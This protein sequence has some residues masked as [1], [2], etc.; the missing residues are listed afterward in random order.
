MINKIIKNQYLLNMINKIISLL[1]GILS[2]AFITRY[3][4]SSLKG[5]YS[6]IVSV[7]SVVSIV[8]NF[9]IYQAY[10]YQIKQGLKNAQKKFLNIFAMQFILYIII[11]GTIAICTKDFKLAGIALIIPF[12]VLVSQVTMIGMVE[13]PTF[14]SF[15]LIIVAFVNVILCYITFKF[16]SRN[17]Y[18]SIAILLIKDVI[19]II[20]VLIKARVFPNPFIIDVKLFFE[21]FKFGLLPMLTTLLLNMNY[22]MDIVMLRQFDTSAAVGIYSVGVS[23]ADY[24]WLIP[25]SF[26]E[27]LFSRAAKENS[28]NSFNLSIKLSTIMTTVISIGV[29]SLGR[30]VISFLY[31]SE[32]F[33]S[34][35]ITVILLIGIPFMSIFKIISPLFVSQGKTKLYFIILLV[36]IVINFVLNYILIAVMSLSG[37]AFATIISQIICGMFTLYM[38][39]KINN[40]RTSSVFMFNR[41]EIDNIKSL[42]IKNN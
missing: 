36:T 23:I 15:A 19:F 5:E 27:V 10:P 2:S 42:L 6:Y 8:L 25:D 41:N 13:F 16:L 29:F 31:G 3:M 4:G 1:L 34:F 40:I 12:N 39:I 7:S 35:D 32:F 21:T 14:R 9:G 30:N 28:V 38:Y 37:A 20:M 18:Y 22:K 24:L 11:S 17:L 33:N 26:K